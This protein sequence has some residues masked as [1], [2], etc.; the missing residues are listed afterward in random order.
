M[1]CKSSLK[2]FF[3]QAQIDA[4]IAAAPDHVDDP[5]SPYDMNDPE[6]IHAFWSKAVLTF[7]GSHP[8]QDP[9]WRTK[10]KRRQTASQKK[11][12]TEQSTLSVKWDET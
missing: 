10:A 12:E 6:E 8:H 11:A 3:T 9:L 5:D 7:P 2:Q 1:E 4:A